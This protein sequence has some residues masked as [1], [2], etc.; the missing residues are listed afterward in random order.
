MNYCAKCGSPQNIGER[1]CRGCGAPIN[2]SQSNN[3][4]FY[5]GQSYNSQ[6]T[7]NN[8]AVATD[9]TKV[10]SILAYLLFFVPLLAGAHKTSEIVKFHTNQGIVIAISYGIWMILRAIIG[11]IAGYVFGFGTIVSLLFSLTSLVFLTLTVI[12]VLNA[13]NDRMKPLP[14]IGRFVILK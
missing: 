13:A 14:V 7:N 10:F 9:N 4:P 8:T 2:S 6:S 1:Y 11:S 3:S 5:G 12:G